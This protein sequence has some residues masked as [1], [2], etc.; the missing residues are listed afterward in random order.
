MPA[1]EQVMKLLREKRSYLA[2]EY[3]VKKMGVFGSYAKGLPNETSDVDIIV[4]FERP[5]GFKFI[6]LIEY[7]EHLLGSKVDVLTLAGLQGIRVA[8]VAQDI[9]ETI[10][11]V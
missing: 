4:E 3:G 5:I 10:V 1:K 6:E 8:R 7:L 2:A 9:T 11:Y